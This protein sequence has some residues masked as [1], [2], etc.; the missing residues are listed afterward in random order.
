NAGNYNNKITCT[1][2]TPLPK[3]NET[4]SCSDTGVAQ[5][6]HYGYRIKAVNTTYS[7]VSELSL[8][9]TCVQ[10]TLCSVAD[11]PA[12]QGPPVLAEPDP[13][14]I[15]E[16]KIPLVWSD[17]N[18]DRTGYWIKR[19]TSAGCIPSVITDT[20]A[21]TATTYSDTNALLPGMTYGYTVCAFKTATHSW[22]SCSTTVQYATTKTPEELIPN[23][24]LQVAPVAG[25]T[26]DM[27]LT[28]SD[29]YSSETNYIINRCTGSGCAT[30][31][32][33]DPGFT[34]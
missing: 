12:K 21:A 13:I 24:N 27:K 18:S 30:T 2:Q 1:V 6:E 26:T 9:T 34:T 7:W 22:D 5:N 17:T 3:F 33:N 20:V 16:A 14:N 10:P 31:F 29:P 11:T 32:V 25:S 28:W 19:C 8:D 15:T 23:I 4:G